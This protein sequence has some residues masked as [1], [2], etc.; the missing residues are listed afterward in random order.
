MTSTPP[1]TD[2]LL[3]LQLVRLR[4]VVD[5]VRDY[6][7]SVADAYLADGLDADAVADRVLELL[8]EVP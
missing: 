4:R 3:L 5:D 6:C 1:S 7:T 8:R 2:V